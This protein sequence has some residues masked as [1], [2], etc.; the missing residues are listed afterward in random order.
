MFAS[1]ASDEMNAS[2]LTVEVIASWVLG[3]SVRSP[4]AVVE[5]AVDR[6]APADTTCRL[7]PATNPVRAARR[8]LVSPTPQIPR[9]DGS[10]KGVFAKVP[11]FTRAEHSFHTVE[12]VDGI[13][14]SLALGGS[15]TRTDTERLLDAC[16]I[17]Q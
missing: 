7:M 2:R 3:E 17:G 14:R 5:A 6:V 4:V 12:D 1:R 9:H 8:S 16:Q 13:R 15:L 11:G 10:S